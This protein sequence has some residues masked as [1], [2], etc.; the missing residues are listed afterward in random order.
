ML[1]QSESVTFD[2]R[3]PPAW[4]LR[5]LRGTSPGLEEDIVRLTDL[6]SLSKTASV[7]GHPRW[8]RRVQMNVLLEDVEGILQALEA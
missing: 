2:N 1:E 3:M 8:V 4:R 5:L 7:C 6:K